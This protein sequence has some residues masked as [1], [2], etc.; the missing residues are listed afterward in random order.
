METCYLDL[1]DPAFRERLARF[2]TDS[3]WG[4]VGRGV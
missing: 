3:G 4:A 1:D 2:P